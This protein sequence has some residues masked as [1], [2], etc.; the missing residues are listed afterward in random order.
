MTR[1]EPDK[2]E[3]KFVHRIYGENCAG[4]GKKC[5]D[6]QVAHLYE[7]ATERKA[8]RYS[9]IILCAECNKAEANAKPIPHRIIELL[10]P[11]NVQQ[12]AREKYK[13]GSYAQSYASCRLASYLYEVHG[14]FTDAVDCL[15]EAISA[16][17]PL[18]WG[19]F[20]ADTA[21][22]TERLCSQSKVGE[23]SRWLFLD[24]LA[25]ALYDYRL[26][27][28]SSDVQSA[29][30]LLIR[31][32][33]PPD[34]PQGR[35]F[36][37]AMSFRRYALI[38][39]S[40]DSMDRG[41]SV[42]M[43]IDRL[44]DDASGFAAMQEL[45]PFATNLDVA[46]KLAREILDEPELAHKFSERALQRAGQIKHWWVLQE[47][48]FREASYYH[49]KGSPAETRTAVLEGLRIREK[50][51]VILEPMLERSEIVPHDI[52]S[53]LERFG[54]SWDEL[55][56][57]GVKRVRPKEEPIHLKKSEIDRIT[58]SVLGS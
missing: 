35:A 4:C 38:R 50:F 30:R 13:K 1:I 49:D 21:L 47:L 19:N 56:D 20:I 57:D 55:L 2:A 34:N 16:L 12:V 41:E 10:E 53:D 33:P 54:I 51:P 24:R 23:S 37:I 52:D 18:R 11:R 43:H 36:D 5:M 58:K 42:R 44:N 22:V 48:Y 28:E 8:D 6:P 7:D 39:V 17:R 31:K 45:D 14:R 25:L 29:A 15:M 3:K 32:L 27:P 26:W 40:T 9:L 46:G